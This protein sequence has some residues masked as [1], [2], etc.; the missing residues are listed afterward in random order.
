M[1]SFIAEHICCILSRSV[2]KAFT[3]TTG[4][5]IMRLGEL[6]EMRTGYPFRKRIPF[7]EKD[8]CRLVQMGDV[9]CLLYTSD[10]ADE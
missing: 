6:V 4:T 2:V 10:A 1:N 5:S 8:G 9:S 7:V 3:V